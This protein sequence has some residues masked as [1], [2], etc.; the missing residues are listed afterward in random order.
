LRS[1]RCDLRILAGCDPFYT[2]HEN[3]ESMLVADWLCEVCKQEI[4]TIVRWVS[5]PQV[6]LCPDRKNS[7]PDQKKSLSHVAGN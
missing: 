7:L 4:E 6:F 2:G 1:S 3:A 5:W